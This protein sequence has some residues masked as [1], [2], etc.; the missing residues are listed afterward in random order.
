MAEKIRVLVVDDEELAR[1]RVLKLLQARPDIEVLGEC[2]DGR[3]AVEKI[4]EKKPDLVFLDVQ[5]PELDGFGVLRALAPEEM[6]AVIFVTAHDKFA[7]KAFEVRA[8]DYLLKPFDRERFETALKRATDQIKS[9]QTG[10]LDKRVT[11]LLADLKPQAKAPERLVVKT[12]GRVLLVKFDDVDWIEAADNYVNVHVGPDSYMLRETMTS[13]EGKFPQDKFV[14]ISRSTIVNVDR[15]KE[16][17]PMFHGEYVVVLRTGA[18]LTL[19][20]TCRDKLDLI[21]G[22][23]P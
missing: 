7:L 5:M 11:A 18:K 14:R 13:M 6:P 16:L 8:I 17:Q 22:K 1:E 3:T 2:G 10:E 12:D 23:L 9:K 21:L 20:R 19:S 4:L 15:I